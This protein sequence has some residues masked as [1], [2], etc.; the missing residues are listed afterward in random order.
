MN[1]ARL[2]ASGGGSGLAPVAPGTAGSLAGAA[3]GALVLWR[4]PW[5]L[6]FVAVATI[7]GGL[8]AVRLATGL[9]WRATAKAAEDDP[10]WVVIDEIAGQL[11]ALLLLPAPSWIGILLAFALFRL[12][13]IA[14]PGPIG[15]LDR[16]GGA[17]GIMADDV[18]AGLVAGVLVGA[19]HWEWSWVV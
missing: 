8:V 12:L 13:D 16:Q 10:G 14:K 19:A 6:P 9:P 7:A 18:L 15:W 4:A 3:L 5:L 17:L 11:C 1:V 2:I